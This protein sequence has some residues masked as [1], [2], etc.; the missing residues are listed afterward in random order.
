MFLGGAKEF[1]GSSTMEGHTQ[2]MSSKLVGLHR[3]I[4]G[5]QLFGDCTS[6]CRRITIQ[7][8]TRL[9]CEPLYKRGNYRSVLPK[10][11]R[12]SCMWDWI[13]NFRCFGLNMVSILK[14]LHMHPGRSFLDFIKPYEKTYWVHL[15]H[16]R[17]KL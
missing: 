4:L 1:Y 10:H 13:E 3:I 9:I 12:R 7:T 8:C 6:H 16:H 2:R 15:I 14:S 11:C 5:G 17:K